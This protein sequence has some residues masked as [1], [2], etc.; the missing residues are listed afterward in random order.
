MVRAAANSGWPGEEIGIQ[1][2]LFAQLTT[3][4]FTG[5]LPRF[6]LSAGRNPTPPPMTHQQNLGQVRVE[7]PDLGRQRIL[8]TG[9]SGSHPA[10][11]VVKFD[12]CSTN[13]AQRGLQRLPL[14]LVTTHGCNLARGYDTAGPRSPDPTSS[15]S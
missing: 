1:P 7:H 11:D 4:C 6:D 13:V 8:R 3:C 14:Q 15:Q 5:R 10:C 12:P 2:G 9:T